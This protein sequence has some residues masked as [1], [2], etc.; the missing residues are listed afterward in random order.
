VLARS[1]T[2]EG[3]RCFLTWSR[4]AATYLHG[5]GLIS[6]EHLDEVVNA[7]E[8]AVAVGLCHV[9]NVR[10][11]RRAPSGRS[12]GARVGMCDGL[13]RTGVPRVFDFRGAFHSSEFF[14]RRTWVGPWRHAGLGLKEGR[15]D[16]CLNPRRRRGGLRVTQ[17][18]DRSLG[19]CPHDP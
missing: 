19:R 13:V 8:D 3:S 14:V 6:R 9:L 18:L 7:G 15:D 11:N 17:G 4:V 1:L 12:G 2:A 5:D 16:T 10:R